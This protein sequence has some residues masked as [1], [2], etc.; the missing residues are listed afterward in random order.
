MCTENVWIFSPAK[1]IAKRFP[2]SLRT[3]CTY[4]PCIWTYNTAVVS[5]ALCRRRDSDRF[6]Q[7][8]SPHQNAGCWL[9]QIKPKKKKPVLA[10]I[11]VRPTE[12]IT[13][14][15]VRSTLPANFFYSIS[16]E[17]AQSFTHTVSLSLPLTCIYAH[18][19]SYIRPFLLNVNTYMS[20]LL[21]SGPYVFPAIAFLSIFVPPTPTQPPSLSLYLCGPVSTCD[22]FD[23]RVEC[24]LPH[25]RYF[26][27]AED[28]HCIKWQPFVD[29]QI[30]SMYV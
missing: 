26:R 30:L 25:F 29:S 18:I 6:I 17:H 5:V 23:N 9:D 12:S 13:V 2:T 4:K 8:D 21:P 1:Y 24:T 11:S 16:S 19:H 20:F 28:V 7:I 14:E 15:D 3:V 10:F 22:S 27:I